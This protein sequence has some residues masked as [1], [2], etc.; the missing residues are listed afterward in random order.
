MQTE[1]TSQLNEQKT[2]SSY[3]VIVRMSAVLKRAI[4]GDWAEVVFRVKWTIIIASGIH[5]YV[6]THGSILGP[7][8]FVVYI[9][10]LPQNLLK[11]SIGMYADDTVIYFD[12]SAETSSSR[13]FKTI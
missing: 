6:Q 2:L 7:I 1:G 12:S 4:V 8:L 13:I 11:S 10:D 3:C 9:N 5:N